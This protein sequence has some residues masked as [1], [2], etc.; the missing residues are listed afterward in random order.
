MGS[1]HTLDTPR[2][3]L[4]RPRKPA[5]SGQSRLRADLLAPGCAAAL[6]YQRP[7]GRTA[8]GPHSTITSRPSQHQHIVLG[9]HLD[10]LLQQLFR[11]GARYVAPHSL[12]MPPT[13][14]MS[15]SASRNGSR[16]SRLTSG[17]RLSLP[18]GEWLASASHA[19]CAAEPCGDGPGLRD[20][21]NFRSC[22]MSG[23]SRA[24][25]DGAPP[26]PPPPPP[27]G[28]ARLPSA[29]GLQPKA[30]AFSREAS[31][32][33][34]HDG[35]PA[36]AGRPQLGEVRRGVA[37]AL[38]RVSAAVESADDADAAPRGLAAA[39]FSRPC[40]RTPS[41][42]GGCSDSPATGST[43]WSIAPGRPPQLQAPASGGGGGGAASADVMEAAPLSVRGMYTGP[44]AI[45]SGDSFDSESGLPCAA[46]PAP[47]RAPRALPDAI[48]CSAR[49]WCGTPSP[50]DPAASLMLGIA[51]AAE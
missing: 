13:S 21:A 28:A 47:P 4:C 44:L 41:P 9:R 18:K 27:P 17:L 19:S 16:R 20:D 36:G 46:A 51:S 5:T 26:P 2:R 33:L 48:L 30:A 25:G 6:P 8:R 45:A 3:P 24:G 43:S 23:V 10:R 12:P 31:A 37:A 42:T 35:S 50:P 32:I 29:G 38:R 14:P 7:D 49:D 1:Q 34:T 15:A 11:L 40:A 39:R 22:D